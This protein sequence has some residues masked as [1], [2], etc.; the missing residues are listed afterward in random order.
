MLSFLHPLYK[1][2]YF[3]IYS[4]EHKFESLSSMYYALSIMVFYIYLYFFTLLWNVLFNGA[5]YILNSLTGFPS[6]T[7]IENA[8][9]NTEKKIYRA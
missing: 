3:S 4:E 5:L 1:R 9:N 2:T 7:T 8:E 6:T